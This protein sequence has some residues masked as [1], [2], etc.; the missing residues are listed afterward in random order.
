MKP[1]SREDV[2]VLGILNGPILEVQLDDLVGSFVGV[3]TGNII[4]KITA[5]RKRCFIYAGNG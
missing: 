2:P 5:A 1:L 4:G 3:S